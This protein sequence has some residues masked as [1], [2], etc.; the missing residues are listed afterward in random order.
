MRASANHVASPPRC[1]CLMGRGGLLQVQLASWGTRSNLHLAGCDVRVPL[2]PSNGPRH[3]RRPRASLRNSPRIRSSSSST[4]CPS[5]RICNAHGCYC[6]SAHPQ[7]PTMPFGRCLLPSP[8]LTQAHM[9]PRCG[10]H[11]RLSWGGQASKSAAGCLQGFGVAIRR[12][13]RASGLLGRMGRRATGL[14]RPPTWAQPFL[15]PCLHERRVPYGQAK[16]NDSALCWGLVAS[17][18]ILAQLS[19]P[20]RGRTGFD[21]NDNIFFYF[22]CRTFS[23]QSAVPVRGM[24]GSQT[25][26]RPVALCESPRQDKSTAGKNPRL[27]ARPAGAVGWPAVEQRRSRRG[28]R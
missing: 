28:H 7:G 14:S 9:M 21:P 8:Q 1:P 4:S 17:P 10:Q 3:P 23:G 5:C 22:F 11:C 15:G 18:H 27:T 6:G 19:N 26:R 24:T 12:A 20:G 13:H 16:D 25:P 2:P